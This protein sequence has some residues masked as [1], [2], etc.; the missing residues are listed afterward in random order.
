MQLRAALEAHAERE[1]LGF[2][3]D[4]C[5]LLLF[6]RA[7]KFRLDEAVDNI[8]N[9]FRFQ[10]DMGWNAPAPIESYRLALESGAMAALGS[11]GTG[12]SV[13][14]LVG[15][16]FE[17]SR[18]ALI[19]F[20]RA[21]YLL[22]HWMVR[23]DEAQIR[24]FVI[25]DDMA[26]MGL[27]A[28]SNERNGGSIGFKMMQRNFPAR[29]KAFYV[30]HQPWFVSGIFTVARPFLS[31]KTKERIFMLGGDTATLVQALGDDVVP[32]QFGGHATPVWPRILGEIYALCR[33]ALQPR[34]RRSSYL[35][36]GPNGAP[37]SVEWGLELEEF[38]GF[39]TVLAV[40]P[41]SLG[42]RFGLAVGDYL[43]TLNGVPVRALPDLRLPRGSRGAALEFVRP[44]EEERAA[45]DLAREA[46]AA[47]AGTANSAPEIVVRAPATAR[48]PAVTPGRV[49]AAS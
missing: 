17:A 33:S 46:R 13:L 35:E 40:E 45:E 11:D 3:L 31:R 6:A 41:G 48:V 22:L 42:L 27:D 5:F 25:I 36:F 19:D 24:G 34:D 1:A 14:A 20:H 26:G 39:L 23:S 47:A 37:A 29:M 44:T 10:R 16:Q 9:Y 18:C 28:A 15:R 8:V 2:R 43:E 32:P 4:L 49:G 7:R 21:L 38:A 30:L 12:R